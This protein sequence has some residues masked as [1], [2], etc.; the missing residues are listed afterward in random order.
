MSVLEGSCE[1]KAVA[2]QGLVVMENWKPMP[3]V[4]YFNCGSAIVNEFEIGLIGDVCYE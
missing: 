2:R 3:D 4:M 1:D